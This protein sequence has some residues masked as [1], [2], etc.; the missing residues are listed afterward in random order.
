MKLVL[1]AEDNK[2]N[3]KV[4]LLMLKKMDYDYEVEIAEN[5]AEAVKM[6][7]LKEYDLILM[8]IHMPIKDGYEAAQ[9]IAAQAQE[10]GKTAPIIIALTADDTTASQNELQKADFDVVLTKPINSQK[11]QEC[12]HSLP[13]TP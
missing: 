9:E 1:I 5:G 11:L 2:I 8:D 6:A 13:K 3:Q 10:A 4:L 12:L 7:Q